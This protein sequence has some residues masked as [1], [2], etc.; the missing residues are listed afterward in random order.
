MSRW[1]NAT[2]GGRTD[3]GWLWCPEYVEAEPEDKVLQ[4]T[5][6]YQL[7]LFVATRLKVGG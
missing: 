2:S 4:Y 7:C 1:E 6:Y 3:R 5:Q